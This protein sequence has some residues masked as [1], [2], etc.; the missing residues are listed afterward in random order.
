MDKRCECEKAGQEA[1]QT[2]AGFVADLLQE[3]ATCSIEEAARALGIGR[4]TA[5]AAAHDGTLPTVRISK[6]ILVP[7][8]KLAALLGLSREREAGA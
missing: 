4:S 1:A 8:S 5:Y 3:R 6:R 7:T 2:T